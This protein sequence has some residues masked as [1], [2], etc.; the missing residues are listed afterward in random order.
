MDGIC[1]GTEDLKG[2]GITDTL[3]AI[4]GDADI[5]TLGDTLGVGGNS[6]NISSAGIR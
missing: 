6:V 2:V 4:L 5:A 1:V 3:G